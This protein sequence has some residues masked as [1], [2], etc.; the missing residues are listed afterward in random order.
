MAKENEEMPDAYDENVINL[1]SLGQTDDDEKKR[2]ETRS[3]D[4]NNR[5]MIG[6]Q[7]QR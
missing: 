5:P 4:N 1:R 2:N 7:I 3:N 6:G